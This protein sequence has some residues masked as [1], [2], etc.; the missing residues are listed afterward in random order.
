VSIQS[1]L[2]LILRGSEA[3]MTNLTDPNRYRLGG[4]PD[5]ANGGAKAAAFLNAGN[6]LKFAPKKNLN[7]TLSIFDAIDFTESGNT[8]QDDV[9]TDGDTDWVPING[10][11]Q[12]IGDSSRGYFLFPTESDKNGGWRRPDRS[13]QFNK[14]AVA[15]QH[16][17]FF[18][19]L[20]AAALVL[21]K[22]DAIIAGT[23]F[24]G[25]DTHST[26]GGATGTHA[27]LN[28]AIGWALY[29]LYKYFTLYSDKATW[30]NT[31]V[32]TLSEFGRTTRQNSD[33]GTDHAEGSVMWVAGGGVKG[34]GAGNPSGIFNCH[35]NDPIPWVT[36]NSGS[37]FQVSGSYLRRTTDYRSVLGEVIRK[38]LGATQ[39]QLSRIIPGYALAGE[40]LLG[41]GASS[42]D[43]T[44][45]RGELGIL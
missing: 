28:K 16:H 11:G 35:P 27:D 20:K 10:G 17:S 14:Y 22:T 1:S 29:G 18:R 4:I 30:D 38:H 36:G 39:N 21:N 8:F 7:N 2:P 26:Q 31:I 43:G 5:D 23:E 13:A 44:Q 24:G 32:M 40:N 37:M 3:A 12:S 19:N 41:G 6:A 9:K 33:L 15:T 45:I 42:I 34:Y 25:F